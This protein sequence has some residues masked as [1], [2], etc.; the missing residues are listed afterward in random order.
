MNK[1]HALSQV[2]NYTIETDII[3]YN[4]LL[5]YIIETLKLKMKLPKLFYQNEI[6]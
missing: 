4:S 3:S 2:E 5:N 1:T 6:T